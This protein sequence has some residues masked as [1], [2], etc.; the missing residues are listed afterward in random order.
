MST[1]E[2]REFRYVA[3]RNFRRCRSFSARHHDRDIMTGDTGS[4]TT[5]NIAGNI[6]GL[7]RE[8]P[9]CHC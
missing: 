8:K 7:G 1:S 6:A 5:G 2:T 3:T 9:T 4:T